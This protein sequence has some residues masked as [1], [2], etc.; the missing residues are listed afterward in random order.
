[1]LP[2]LDILL[3]KFVVPLWAYKD[4]Q[5]IQVL[6]RNIRVVVVRLFRELG[7][8]CRPDG[9]AVLRVVFESCFARFISFVWAVPAPATMP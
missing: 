7:S 6:I 2:P 5:C 8:S 9:E 4:G 1:M 3:Q